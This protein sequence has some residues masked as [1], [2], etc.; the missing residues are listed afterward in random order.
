MPSLEH[1]T[2]ALAGQSL[3]W[4]SFQIGRRILFPSKNDILTGRRFFL[5]LP[6][7]DSARQVYR[8]IN[9]L[10]IP[11]VYLSAWEILPGE[12]NDFYAPNA[13]ARAQAIDAIVGGSAPVV[14]ATHKSTVQKI[15]P[16][17]QR[18]M[19][20]RHGYR[21]KI[22]DLAQ[23]L[24]DKGYVRVP[25]VDDFGQ[26]ALRGDIMDIYCPG[27]P[28]RLEFFDEELERITRFDVDT[29]TSLEGLEELMVMQYREYSQSPWEL[30]RQSV[31]SFVSDA[32]ILLFDADHLEMVLQR[33]RQQC[34]S[35]SADRILLNLADIP[36]HC[37]LLPPP[38]AAAG[39]LEPAGEHVDISQRVERC[40]DIL[41]RTP[42]A[43]LSYRSEQAR[44]KF[45]ALLQ[46]HG[47]KAQNLEQPLAVQEGTVLLPADFQDSFAI[48]DHRVLIS[49]R[50]LFGLSR[51]KKEQR[52]RGMTTYLTDL[53]MLR[54][55]DHVVHVEYGVGIFR[56]IENLS[57]AGT[58]GDFLK[59]EYAR[60]DILYVPNDKFHL[61]QKYIGS[62]TGDP[63]LDRM[64][65]KSW[66]KRKSRARKSVEDIAESLMQ[67]DALRRRHKEHTYLRDSSLYDEFVAQFPY[68]E[69]EDQ[70]QAIK[71][72][73]ED[74]CSPHPMDRLVCGD[75]GYGKTEIALRAA[76]KCVESGYQA[77]ILA[78]TTI[79]VE[80]HFRTFR[81]RFTPFGIR[82]D[83]LSRFRTAK[84][85]QDAIARLAAG[86]IDIVIGTHK[87]LGKGVS[88]HNLALLVIDEEQRFGVTHKEKLKQFKANVDV[89]TLTATPIPRTLHMAMGGIKKMSVIETPP[90]DRRAIKTEVIEF[91]D[92]ILRQGLMR[93]FHRGGQIY[94]LHNRVETINA[95]ALRVQGLIPEARVAVAH[96]QMSE[97]QLE[98]VM[99]EFSAGEHDVLVCSSIV[100]SGLDVPR[101]NTIFINRADTLGLAQLYQLRGRVGRSERRAF[102][103]LIIPPFDTLHDVA[104]KRIR[105]IEE[106]SYLGAG[107]RLATY[108]LEIRGAGNLLGM[109][110][111]GQI[112]S[113]GFEMYT[114][115]LRECVQQ[116]RGQSEELFEPSVRTEA[117]AFIPE[118]YV[119]DMPARLSLYKRLGSVTSADEIARLSAELRDR[120]GSL[121]PEVERLLWVT[122]MKILAR[123]LH[124]DQLYLGS[125][126][127]SFMVSEKS[128]VNMATIIQMAVERK[129]T[130]DPQGK[131][132]LPTESTE[133]TERFLLAIRQ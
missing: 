60:G 18:I 76:M 84:Q 51:P 41:R 67:T 128:R 28:F 91:Q 75:V 100:E 50:E 62:D 19:E 74:M 15:P 11:C 17:S 24:V 9:S 7:D 78:P 97:A 93:E 112:A 111:S 72:T 13:A 48:D 120:F 88:F 6:D 96:G 121:P 43:F 81:E 3:S 37:V 49:D 119:E 10:N 66:E 44:D 35:I 110:Q 57:A 46:E 70:L 4:I 32:D 80:Q 118:T 31:F 8:T 101:A 55:G 114:D 109:E 27:G 79:L 33:E 71:E 107:F 56:G 98:R 129:L 40:L 106:L 26:F 99:L 25:I 127:S 29:Q 86:E 47:I 130:L 12:A 5:S 95:I 73:I 1:T 39:L 63:K 87:L 132:T 85:N 102:C 69:T 124:I 23:T 36:A 133:K 59:I 123:Q 58:R 103:Y 34:Q 2:H 125:R 52:F 38:P 122:H 68:E 82:V 108:D 115:M 21:Y 22:D 14:V 77:A 117:A 94:F 30:E 116:L 45:Q 64:G 65:S 131:V 20:L 53:A 83:M 61:V 42:L 113:V 16:V 54:P 92:E 89:L 90:K 105:V 126:N 104:Q